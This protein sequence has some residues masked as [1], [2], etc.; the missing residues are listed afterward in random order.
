MEQIDQGVKTSVRTT[1]RNFIIQN[2]LFGAENDSFVDHDSFLSTGIMD[3]T[4]I[5]ELIEFLEES[6]Q[7]KIQDDEMLPE[8]LDSIDNVCSFVTRKMGNGVGS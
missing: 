8:N 4:G 3:S 5:L 2:F 6:Y 7:I 1:V